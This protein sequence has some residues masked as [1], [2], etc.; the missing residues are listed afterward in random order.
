MPVSDE[1]EGAFFLQ[2]N[3]NKRSITL[4]RPH[5]R[6]EVRSFASP[7]RDVVVAN[8][9]LGR[10]T[11]LGLD[12]DSPSMIKADIILTASGSALRFCRKRSLIESAS[13]EWPRL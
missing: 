5:R 10:L 2:V 3:R 7:L 11:S 8:M 6:R 4:I 9:P 12:Y 13:M 1:G